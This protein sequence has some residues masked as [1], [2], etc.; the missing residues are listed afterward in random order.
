MQT[1]VEVSDPNAQVIF[2]WA[3]E[4]GSRTLLEHASFPQHKGSHGEDTLPFPGLA[5]E[6]PAYARVNHGRWIIDCPFG[7]GG[8]EMLDDS[9]PTFFCCE[10]RNAA[11]YHRPV[12]VVVPDNR[13]FIEAVLLRR[14]EYPTRN[15][16]P[17]ETI[18]DLE[19]ENTARG[20]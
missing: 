10:C 12:V 20:L 18:A 1:S 16:R 7:C 11:T 17:G 8:A 13:E 3:T 9:R 19:A 5:M 15:W 4:F 14:P 6:P 2:T